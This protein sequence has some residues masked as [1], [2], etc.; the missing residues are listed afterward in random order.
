MKTFMMR[1]IPLIN[2]SIGY[3]LKGLK[4]QLQQ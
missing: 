4:E 2:S 1:V 3:I